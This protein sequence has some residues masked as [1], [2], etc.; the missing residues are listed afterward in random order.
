M[1]HGLIF[2]KTRR[3]PLQT[4]QWTVVGHLHIPFDSLLTACGLNNVLIRKNSSFKC[5]FS[6]FTLQ[7]KEVFHS[8][9]CPRIALSLS[10]SWEFQSIQRIVT[11][12]LYLAVN[13][14]LTTCILNNDLI[15]KTYHLNVCF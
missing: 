1:V 11:G 4:A 2:N 3:G 14:L 12:H 9:G 13:I 5:L 7:L 15:Y 6:I 10:R 8:L